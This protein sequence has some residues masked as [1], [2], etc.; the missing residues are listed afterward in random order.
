MKKFQIAI[1]WITI[2]HNHNKLRI[3]FVYAVK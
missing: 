1:T 2:I 3:N